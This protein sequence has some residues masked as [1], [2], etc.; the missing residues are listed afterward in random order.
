MNKRFVDILFCLILI[1]PPFK[2]AN[3]IFAFPTSIGSVFAHDFIIWPL[4]IGLIYTIYCEWKYGNVVYK[5]NKFKNYI[6]IYLFVLLTSLILG[7]IYYPYW[8][9]IFNGQAMNNPK[10]L[11]IT[12]FF[13]DVGIDID[14]SNIL[15]TWIIIKS[16]K[17]IILNIFYTFGGAY[18]IVCWYHNRIERALHLLKNITVGLLIVI[19]V[20]GLIDMCYQNGQWWAQNFISFMWPIFHS[21]I[22]SSHYPIF[23]DARNRSL[24][25]E[26]SYFSIYMAFAFPILWWKIIESDG[27]YRI[28][29]VILYL[30]LTVEIYLGQS[31]TSMVLFLSELFILICFT[32]Y[33]K[34][35]ELKLISCFLIVG[36]LISFGISMFFLQ[37]CQV[38]AELGEKTPLATKKSEMLSAR[39]DEI[40]DRNIGTYIDDSL[41]SL[42]DDEKAK[43]R[44][45][46]NHVRLGVTFA[47]IEIGLKHPI[48]GTG[49]GLDTAYLYEVF[50]DDK[51]PEI[52][53]DFIQPIEDKGL[54]NT[55]SLIMCEYSSQFMQ[56]GFLGLFLFIL[57]MGYLM[58]RL[59]KRLIKK[60][61]ERNEFFTILFITMSDIGI[62]ITGFGNILNITY[63]YWLMIGISFVV[64][65]NLQEKENIILK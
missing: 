43:K 57:P 50:R 14:Q 42:V 37:Y 61:E 53:H 47:N 13:N 52:R 32:F 41:M 48:L 63:C 60:K 31:R 30:I 55:N 17:N 16:I 8:D 39:P 62:S 65:F 38:P 44:S 3:H 4:S 7:M 25:L 20:Y 34:S 58:I 28:A 2:F 21:N 35:R 5:W 18:M 59:L 56:S 22:E 19:A 51:N 12:S 1:S 46:S 54:L 10:I 26:A 6:I 15:P 40:K 23:L 36:A 29:L 49:Y 45:G 9:M 27:K 33:N 64:E 24:F 11:L